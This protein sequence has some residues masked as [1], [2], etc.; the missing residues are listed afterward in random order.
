MKSAL[1]TGVKIALN[2]LPYSLFMRMI[3]FEVIDF[4]ASQGIGIIGYSPLCQ[5]TKPQTPF[6]PSS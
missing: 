6:I 4:C 3:E 1:A 2:Q 5:G